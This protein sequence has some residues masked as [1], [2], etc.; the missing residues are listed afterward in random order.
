[1]N[2]GLLDIDGRNFPN[3][4]LMKIADALGGMS[5]ADVLASDRFL[6]NLSAYLDAQK[7]DRRKIRA[8]YAAMKRLGFAKGYRL[9]AHVIDRFMDTTADEFARLYA[10]L[11]DRSVWRP[12]AERQYVIQLGRQAFNLTAVQLAAEKYPELE[13]L[14]QNQ[15]TCNR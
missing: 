7:E 9:P 1:M 3:V 4:A 12:F 14:T 15:K 5:I 6:K 8:S 2:V 13:Y 11:T 10:G